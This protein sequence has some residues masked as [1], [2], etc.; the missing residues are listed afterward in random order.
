[1]E[2]TPNRAKR[3]IL[4]LCHSPAQPTRSHT[5]LC[6]F[7]DIAAVLTEPNQYKDSRSQYVLCFKKNEDRSFITVLPPLFALRQTTQSKQQRASGVTVTFTSLCSPVF[8]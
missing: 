2:F 6:T 8:P 7:R 1:M 5:I 4:I 3:Y